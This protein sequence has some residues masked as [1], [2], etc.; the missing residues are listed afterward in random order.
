MKNSDFTIISLVVKRKIAEAS[1]YLEVIQRNANSL[2][3]NQKG[4]HDQMLKTSR[5][6]IDSNISKSLNSLSN[7]QKTNVSSSKWNFI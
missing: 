2:I 5:K 6:D 4:I 3:K 1:L 7:F